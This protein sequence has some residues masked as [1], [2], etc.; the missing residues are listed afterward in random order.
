MQC[1][2]SH[3]RLNSLSMELRSGNPIGVDMLIFKAKET[4]TAV[5]RYKL[6][7]A[8]IKS[9]LTPIITRIDR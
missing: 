7:Q 4:N 5:S 6:I 9:K 3:A 1:L 2:R 8:Q